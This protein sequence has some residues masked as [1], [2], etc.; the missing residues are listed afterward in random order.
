[1]ATGPK[2]TVKFRRVREGKTNY[3]KRLALLKSRLPRFVVRIS[4]KNVLCQMIE[5]DVAG[6]KIIVS[7]SSKEL[8][9]LGWTGAGS[10]LPA[11]YLTAYLCAKKAIDAKA[12]KAVFDLGFKSIVAGSKSFAALKGAL[13]GGLDIAHD[14]KVL[15]PQDR[16]EGAHIDAKIKTEV[17]AVKA[18][19]DSKK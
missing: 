16:I 19:I 18:K 12:K 4:N 15:P 5:H 2:Y 8:T 13:D 17:N 1:M 6:D 9:K 14:D 11:A 3:K 7:A 10:N